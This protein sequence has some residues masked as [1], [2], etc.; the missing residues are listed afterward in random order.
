MR[1]KSFKIQ[2]LAGQIKIAMDPHLTRKTHSALLKLG[3]LEAWLKTVIHAPFPNFS[4]ESAA[5]AHSRNGGETDISK[6]L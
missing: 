1:S 5:F 6:G 2:P 4:D 3:K